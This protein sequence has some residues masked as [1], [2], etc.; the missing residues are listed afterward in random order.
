MANLLNFAK[1]L[2]MEFKKISSVD[3]DFFHSFLDDKGIFLDD[4]SI[5]DYAHDEMPSTVTNKV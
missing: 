4:E 1:M 2:E 5:H 3:L